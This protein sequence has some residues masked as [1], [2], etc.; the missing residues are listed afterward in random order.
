MLRVVVREDGREPLP[1]VDIEG[2]FTIGGGADA[3]VRLPAGEI[4]GARVQVRAVDVGEPE[5]FVLGRYRVEVGPSP[6]GA[7]ATP[8]QRTE[9]LARELLRDV[10]GTK[11]APSLTIEHGTHAGATRMLAPPESALVIGRGDEAGWVLDDDGL[12][13]T[14]VEVRRG[15]DG[16]RVVDLGSKNG[17]RVDGVRLAEGQGVTIADGT[18]IE[19]GGIRM[20]VKD[21]AEALIRAPTPSPTPTPSRNPTTNPTPSPTPTR[22]AT[23]PPR[24]PI[25]FW[26][27]AVVFLVAL[28]GLIWL[29]IA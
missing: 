28:A 2:D 26:T 22:R 17:T 15:W 10:L 18:V 16:L 5:T 9:S 14:H 23:R 25:V 20:R 29:A 8:P 19:I 11:G 21:P 13:R 12:S 7:I 1:P 3:R 27:A 24:N 6:A 4:A